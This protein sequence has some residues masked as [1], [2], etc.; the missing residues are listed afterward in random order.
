MSKIKARFGAAS[1]WLNLN[2]C[3]HGWTAVLAFLIA[4]WLVF[5]DYASRAALGL[6]R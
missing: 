2:W 3:H 5:F 6:V 4:G 1:A